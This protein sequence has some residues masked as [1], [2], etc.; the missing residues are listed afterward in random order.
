MM[1]HS[2]GLDIYARVISKLYACRRFICQ[3]YAYIH[4]RR[5]QFRFYTSYT[6]TS[7]FLTYMHDT[8][9]CI[10]NHTVYVPCILMSAPT[11][12]C[13]ITGPVPNNVCQ[14]E[15]KHMLQLLPCILGN[16]SNISK[17]KTSMT[18]Y[19]YHLVQ[20]CTVI[21]CPFGAHAL[22]L[23]QLLRH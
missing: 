20:R 17:G 6:H 19:I 15:P 21:R 16:R 10:T 14:Q 1:M 4:L 5:Q 23:Q 8:I 11:F 12:V 13:T 3:T 2:I 22:I 9:H 18:A 7:A